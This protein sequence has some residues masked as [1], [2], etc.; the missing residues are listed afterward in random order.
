MCRMIGEFSRECVRKIK[1]D[2]SRS[3]EI[4]RESVLQ[5]ILTWEDLKCQTYSKVRMN[6]RMTVSMSDFLSSSISR[7][8]YFKASYVYYVNPLGEVI[9][10]KSKY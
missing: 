10:L 1:G 5:F 2:G 8:D 7:E 4:E 9:T 6:P 3:L